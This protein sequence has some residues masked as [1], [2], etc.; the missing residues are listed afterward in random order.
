MADTD[1]LESE[2]E[3]FEAEIRKINEDPKVLERWPSGCYKH[4]D[5]EGRWGGW[6]MACRASRPAEVDDEDPGYKM[7]PVVP[8]DE[9][10]IAAREKIGVGSN[11][12]DHIY[13]TMAAAAP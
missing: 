2:R 7:L 3:R 6:K 10:C 9:M 8:T 11:V 5:V 13:R 1:M 4:Y 12:A